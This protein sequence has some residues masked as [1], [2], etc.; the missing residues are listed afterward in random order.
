MAFL[1][2]AREISTK[3]KR[4]FYPSAPPAADA[5]KGGGPARELLLTP[6]LT[7]L[8]KSCHFFWDSCLPFFFWLA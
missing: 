3:L 4:G 8:Y 1:A 6:N 5:E 2:L 7:L